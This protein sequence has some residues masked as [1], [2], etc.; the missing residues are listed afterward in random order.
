MSEERKENF[1]KVLRLFG[2][3]RITPSP[4]LSHGPPPTPMPVTPSPVLITV[5]LPP[6]LSL[7][8][9]APPPTQLT[10]SRPNQ[11]I[12]IESGSYSISLNWITIL[13]IGL[14]KVSIIL[15]LI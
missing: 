6:A 8:G 15:F 4:S 10:S 11:L 13:T 5:A 12:P 7:M 2:L 14:I 1:K 9:P 3:P